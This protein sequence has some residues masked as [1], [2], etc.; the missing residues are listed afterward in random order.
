MPVG[1][2]Y[3]FVELLWK[4]YIS[5]EGGKGNSILAIFFSDFI[6]GLVARFFFEILV[7]FG[8]DIKLASRA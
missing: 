4:L 3:D 8:E 1:K 5:F 2:C 6:K 7:A